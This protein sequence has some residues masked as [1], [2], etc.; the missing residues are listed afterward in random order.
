MANARFEILLQKF[1]Q[2]TISPAEVHELGD[3]MLAAGSDDELDGFLARAYAD[4][5]LA[6][7]EDFDSGQVR[8]KIL[9]R[10][11]FREQDGV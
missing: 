6:V 11:Q 7:H 2:D 9:A 4:R 5:S 1:V 8:E 10:L 3:L